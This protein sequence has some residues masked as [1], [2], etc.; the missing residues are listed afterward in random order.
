MRL[1]AVTRHRSPLGADQVRLSGRVVYDSGQPAE[2][3][4]WFDL[5]ADYEPFVSDSA[6]PWLACLMPLAATL[7]EPLAIP[8]AGDPV[9]LKNVRGLNEIWKAWYPRLHMVRLDVPAAA[10]VAGE[11]PGKVASLFSG[12]VDGFFTALR[13]LD[14]SAAA[15]GTA[16]D[17]L[18]FVRGFDIPLAERDGYEKTFLALS[19]AAADLGKRLV[20]VATNLRET[21]LNRVNVNLLWH[22]PGLLST[23]LALEKRY[24]VV[25]IPST[26]SYLHLAPWG[27]HPLTD[28][29]LSTTATRIVHDD[30]CFSRTEKLERIAGCPTVLRTLRVCPRSGAHFN[31][32]NCSKCFR[33]MATLEVL[34][35]LDKCATFDASRF[36]LDRLARVFSPDVN[37]R[38]LLDEV[39]RFAAGRARNDIADAI[40]QSLVRSSRLAPGVALADWL[41][42]KR[43]VWRASEPLR[44]FVQR[45]SI[46]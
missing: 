1:D 11:R 46:L 6:D 8:L 3:I 2:E 25:F 31:C 12:G 30:P 15:D 19:D 10:A 34:D 7:G 16:I 41:A 37:S 24:R 33:T 44:R 28:P 35:A 9:L 23:T 42:T 36:S 38:T 43:F 39:A 18:V 20:V 40:R 32:S 29:L 5:P 21:R 4:F 17:D 26:H 27:S 22:G 45:Q 13:H 14:A